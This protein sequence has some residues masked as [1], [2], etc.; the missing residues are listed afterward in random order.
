MKPQ[1]K[2]LRSYTEASTAQCRDIVARHV[3]CRTMCKIQK[4]CE[5]SIADEHVTRAPAQPVRYLKQPECEK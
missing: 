1:L 2:A 3:V 5:G 4:S